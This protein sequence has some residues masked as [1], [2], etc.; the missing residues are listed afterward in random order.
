[1]PDVGFATTVGSSHNRNVFDFEAAAAGARERQPHDPAPRHLLRSFYAALDTIRHEGVVVGSV[2]PEA[3]VPMIAAADIAAVATEALHERNWSG[4]VVCELI[5]PGD[6]TYIE[7]AAAIGAAIGRPDLQYVQLPD[8]EL[9]AILTDAGFSPDFAALFVEFNQALSEG[10]RCAPSGVATR[11][12]R[13]RPNS[14]SS[15]P[16][17]H[18]PT[19]R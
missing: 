15:P 1:V 3:K 18:T 12:T 2:A 10:S 6:L 11:A 13:H 7:A 19:R 16:S 5:G 4:A 17:S 8:E 14:R 9:V